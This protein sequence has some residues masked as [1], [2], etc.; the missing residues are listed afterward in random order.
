M[1][2]QRSSFNAIVR[3][4]SA[5]VPLAMSL[6]ALAL[7]IAHVGGDLIESGHV[8]READEGATAHLWQ[9]LMAAQMP[10]LAF[11]AIRWMPRAPRQTLKVMAL[12]TGAA[13]ANFAVVF[14]LGL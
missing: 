12:Q 13:L 10:V 4:P 11:F 7:V 2:Q 3:Q 1:D 8:I 9:L 14:F 5:F 6:L